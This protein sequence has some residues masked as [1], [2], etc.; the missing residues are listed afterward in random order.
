MPCAPKVT[1]IKFAAYSCLARMTIQQNHPTGP[2]KLKDCA[3]VTTFFV[4]RLCDVIL[5]KPSRIQEVG[6]DKIII[7]FLVLDLS[8]QTP[9]RWHKANPFDAEAKYFL[10]TFS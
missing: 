7:N 2:L 9:K 3:Q 5:S 10:L 6:F 4:I 1:N 8:S